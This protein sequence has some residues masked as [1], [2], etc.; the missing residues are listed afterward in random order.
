ME[1]IN[2]YELTYR[3]F[4]GAL[5]RG[6][7]AIPRGDGPHPGL[8]LFH[9]YN[10]SLDG[11]IHE[12]VNWAGHGY[13]AYMM[14]CRGQAISE[15]NSMSPHGHFAGWMSKGILDKN[16][17]YYR[18]V[19]LD[20]VRALD[21]FKQL[22]G[23]DGSRVGVTG[24]SQGG[25]LSLVAAALSDVPVV[26]ASDYPYLSHFRRAI[27]VAPEGP[28]LEINEFF[29]RNSDP[30]VERTAMTT[31]SYFDVMN[32]APWITCP[33]LISVGMVDTITP[34]STI[35]AVYN[36]IEA[37][38]EITV[39]R[40]FGHEFTPAAHMAKLRFLKAHLRG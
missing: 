31:L 1:G 5:I 4:G 16:T 24:G 34:P 26:C 39:S 27:D 25:A 32:L 3:G 20:A 9:G 33:T 13:A 6:Y 10:W 23:V 30:E 2:V 36:H 15:D 21:V 8:V 14:L 40:Y 38:K 37:P 17:Y 7:Y 22:P 29:R 11:G 18:G 35:F 12:V 28:Y 19:Y